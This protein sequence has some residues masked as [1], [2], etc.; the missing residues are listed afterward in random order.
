MGH[1]QHLSGRARFWPMN[2]D[3]NKR[4]REGSFQTND[5]KSNITKMDFVN[6]VLLFSNGAVLVLIL[7]FLLGVP[8]QEAMDLPSLLVCIFYNRLHPDPVEVWRPFRLLILSC[9]GVYNMVKDSKPGSPLAGFVAPRA[10]EDAVAHEEKRTYDVVS[11]LWTRITKAAAEG[12]AATW[13]ARAPPKPSAAVYGAQS[14]YIP[15]STLAIYDIANKTTLKCGPGESHEDAFEKSRRLCA[16]VSSFGCVYANDPD[17]IPKIRQNMEYH[18]NAIIREF[19]FRMKAEI[20]T[21]IVEAIHLLNKFMLER[22]ESKVDEAKHKALAYCTIERC[23]ERLNKIGELYVHSLAEHPD[24]LKRVANDLEESSLRFIVD[25]VAFEEN[26]DRRFWGSSDLVE[27]GEVACRPPPASLHKRTCA[28]NG[29]KTFHNARNKQNRTEYVLY[30]RAQMCTAWIHMFKGDLFAFNAMLKR[31]S[32]RLNCMIL[33]MN[34]ELEAARAEAKPF[35][36][37]PLCCRMLWRE[38]CEGWE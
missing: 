28:V 18:W 34:G 1:T 23:E 10:A 4:V 37:N 14:A 21:C 29:I 24:D 20:L 7:E 36:F 11:E 31:H 3:S 26:Q 17:R 32:D 35:K 25:R 8:H 27:D 9:S 6:E 19:D 30:D 13:R 2:R 16:D 38:M 33:R 5:S 12:L 15:Y 22:I